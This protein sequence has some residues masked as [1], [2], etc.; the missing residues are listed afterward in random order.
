MTHFIVAVV[1]PPRIRNI[2]SFIARQMEPFDENTDVEPYVAWSV[3]QA[4]QE[5]KSTIHRLELIQ[6]R[7]EKGYDL[8]R[9][10]DSLA[11]L[12]G[13]TAELYYQ[14]RLHCYETFNDRGEP[15]TTYNPDS[16]WDWYVIG[17]RWDGWIHDRVNTSE[18][19]EDNTVTTEEAVARNKIP[20]A[21]IT[22]DGQ[23]HERGRMGWWASLLTEN[24]H[25]DE[26]AKAIFARYPGHQVVIVDAHI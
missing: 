6:F 12:R 5:L 18:R 21:I 1:V 24:E 7:R 15:L 22:P 10:A 8:E 13:T 14:Q 19:L 11:K 2:D 9:I 25:W 17:G 3:D 26:E 23:W 4:Q 20:H 16:K